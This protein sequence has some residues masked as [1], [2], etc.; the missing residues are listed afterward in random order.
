MREGTKLASKNLFVICL[1][2]LQRDYGIICS[3]SCVSDWM[4]EELSSFKNLIIGLKHFNKKNPS[5]SSIRNFDFD[6]YTPKLRILNIVEGY[7]PPEKHYPPLRY[8]GSQPPPGE[9]FVTSL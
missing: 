6:W 8:R 2:I 5:L 4:F 3:T 9:V 1:K 7:R